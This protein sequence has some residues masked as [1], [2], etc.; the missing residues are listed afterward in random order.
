MTAT[1]ADQPR[2]TS[3]PPASTSTTGAIAPS[4]DAAPQAQSHDKNEKVAQPV[5]CFCTSGSQGIFGRS[6]SSAADKQDIGNVSS[7]SSRPQSSQNSAKSQ[8]PQ[9][10]PCK[11]LMLRPFCPQIEMANTSYLLSSSTA[12]SRSISSCVKI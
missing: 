5:C 8:M 4:I 3:A 11:T 9:F 10:L 7:A 1:I 2:V 12:R 6:R